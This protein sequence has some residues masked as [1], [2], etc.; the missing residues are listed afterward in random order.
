[1][2]YTDN[3]WQ[4]PPFD[5]FLSL[6][7]RIQ[8]N[9]TPRIHFRIANWLQ[10]RWTHGDRRVLL[11]A[12]R[13]SGKSSL[14]GLLCAW[15]LTRDPD[16]RI[17][18][19]SAE[20][21][22]SSRMSRNI[23]TIIE[24]HP[25]TAPLI[26]NRSELWAS[27]KFTV[28]RRASWRDPSVWAAGLY[29]NITGARADLIICD[30]VEV[31]NTCET[32]EA[33]ARLRARLSETEFILN[34]GGTMLYIGTPHCYET[35]Y[36]DGS[37][38]DAPVFLQDYARLSVPI[39]TE[40]GESAWP[41]RFPRAQIAL[42]KKQV[43]PLKFAAQMMLQP[44]NIAESRLDPGLLRRYDAPLAAR[45]VQ[46]QLYLS[47][48]GKRIVSCGAWWDPAFG[49][50]NG[51]ASVLAVI[52]ND[53]EGRQ[54]LH[55]LAYIRPAGDDDEAHD[56]CRQVARIA[57]DLYIPAITLET[58]G[59]GKFLPGIL[60][61]VLAEE[62]VPCAV[63]ETVSTRPKDLRIL[64]SFDAVMAAQSLHISAP[65]CETAFL[66][67]MRDW[68]PGLKNARDDGLDAAAGALSLKPARLPRRYYRGRASWQGRP[69]QAQTDFPL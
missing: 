23:R 65:V 33:R 66:R 22:L 38:N 64:E 36:A 31:P 46:G 69:Q 30:D 24:K 18:V 10:E 34:P 15:L 11:Q 27:D 63:Q 13:A 53:D 3:T 6:W 7:N 50:A 45:E 2:K 61:K 21:S 1:M 8:G 55:H 35:I 4:E 9:T 40:D 5:L 51:D 67:E 62:K 47:L 52:F 16:M 57:R 32:A 26:P 43:G 44:V 48:E 37:G 59:I 12:F 19:L 28:N 14:S 58:N 49:A 20:R 29:G 17:L 42:Q 39:L 60:R 41:E 25:L 54:Y 56:Q 68:R